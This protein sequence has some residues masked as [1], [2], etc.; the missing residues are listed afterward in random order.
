MTRTL[1]TARLFLRPCEAGDLEAL[2]ALWT[3][4][5]VRRYLWDDVVIPRETAAEVL[6][7]SHD[8]FARH[9]FGLWTLWPRVGAERL[10]G[11]CGL[12]HFGDPREGDP[13]EV[14]LLY[15]LEP[16][17]WHQGLATEAARA[18]LTFGFETA[19]LS[20]LYAGFDPPNLASRRVLE[21]LGMR[22]ARRV[23]I[24]GIDTIYWSL[25]RETF[26]CTREP[27]SR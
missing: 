1:T 6:R 3:E 7:A 27:A 20:V 10:I 24:D 13:P 21:R 22:Y 14:E 23:S 11:F 25:D 16:A 19:G 12:R 8:S 5:A 4:P 18:V 17:Q 9:G 26:A 15:G 2:H